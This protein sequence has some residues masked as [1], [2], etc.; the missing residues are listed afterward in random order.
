MLV[1]PGSVAYGDGRLVAE[2]APD[3][4]FDADALGAQL[5]LRPWQAGDRMRL[6]TGTRTLQDLFTDHKVPRE[7]RA[8][9]PVV[10]AGGEIAWVPGVAAG[11][12][13]LARRQSTRRVSLRW[14]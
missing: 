11:E 8:H 6:R 7:R 1:V 12:R 13:F 5:A 4:A 2:E 10:V 9:V 14:S 3:G